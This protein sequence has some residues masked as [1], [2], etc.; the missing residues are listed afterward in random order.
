MTIL[1]NAKSRINLGSYD[2]IFGNSYGFLQEVF[3]V[4]VIST[5]V[6]GIDEKVEKT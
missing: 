2:R 5:V 1:C 4:W 3:K 6:T